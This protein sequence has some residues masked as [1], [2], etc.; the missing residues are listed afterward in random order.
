MENNFSL[1]KKAVPRHAQAI[2]REYGIKHVRGE[3]ELVKGSFKTGF[4]CPFCADKSGSASLTDELHF[5]CHQCSYK[6]DIFEWVGR[7]SGIS[8]WDACKAIAERVGVELKARS[9]KAV[10][11]RSMPS[12]MTEEI[13]EIAARDLWENERAQSERDMLKERGFTD[14][15]LLMKLG[16]GWIKGWVVFPS[17]DDQGNMLEKY[18]A[19][20]PN[21]PKVKWRWFGSGSGGPGI[22]PSLPAPEGAKILLC[23]GEGD[24]LTAMCRLRMHEQGWHVAT[25]TAGATSAPSPHHLPVSW[26]G[27]EV[28]VAYDNDVFQGPNYTKYVVLTKPGKN[29]DHARA[30]ARQRL[31][32]LLEGVCPALKSIDCKVIVRQCPV[33][34]AVN[35]GGDLRDWVNDGGNDFNDWK[36][37]PF[38]KLPDIDKVVVDVPFD[39]LWE[40]VGIN[41]RTMM[42]VEALGSDDVNVPETLRM[43][44]ELGQHTSCASCPGCREFPDGSIDMSEWPRELAVGL[45]S[46]N[47]HEYWAKNVVRRPKG[48]PRLELVTERGRKGS[49]WRGMRP[50][51]EEGSAQRSI[52]VV[53][54]DQPSL[55][56]DVEVVGIPHSTVKGNKLLIHAKEVRALDKGVDLEPHAFDFLHHCPHAATTVEEIDRYL[57][58]R[59]RDLSWNVTKVYGRQDVQIAWDLMMHSAIEISVAGSRERGWLDI[60]IIGDTR[61]GKSQTVT[62][63][64]DFTSMGKH[65]T[66]VSNISRAGVVMG[67]D[68]FGMLQPGAFP[69]ANGKALVL[70]ETHFL[71]EN[72]RRCKREHPLSWLQSARAEGFVSGIKNYG[73]R[74]LPARVRLCLIAN[75]MTGKRRNFQYRCQ[76][77]LELYGTPETLARTDFA[78][79]V[80][81]R[82]THST[83]TRTKQWWTPERTRALIQR[84]W[85][86]QPSQ[87]HI[88]E[89]SIARAKEVVREWAG[90]YDSER[91]PLFTVEEKEF[92]L[93]RSAVAIANLCF[94]HSK[95]DINS[96][97]VRPVHIE[98]VKQW[99]EHTWR[100]VQYEEWSERCARAKTVVNPLTAEKLLSFDIGLD[101]YMQVESVLSQMMGP[102]SV[103]QL[104]GM[105]GKNMGEINVWLRK[106][107]AHNVLENN[108][109]H[110]GYGTQYTPTEGGHKLMSQLIAL[111]Q[112]D[113]D[114]YQERQKF[115]Q[116]FMTSQ[117]GK[118]TFDDTLEPLGDEV[119]DDP[120]A[121]PDV[122]F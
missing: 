81:G 77:L 21:D 16:I 65:F 69:R 17:R 94:S 89:E 80:E 58:Q 51:N 35:Y 99:Y 8:Q 106:A 83:L 3:V 82:P 53:G 31:T 84:A 118:I 36:A 26:R 71:V 41:V 114:R 61:S 15:R 78:I 52:L 98:W 24:V 20:S 32:K 90:L 119:F 18:R 59:W 104:A 68:R 122:P 88:S 13:A 44:C 74:E 64:I 4:L 117:G 91:I 28:H 2:V 25:W 9:R 43:E 37:F 97:E 120:F 29:P 105:V 102:N 34:P 45:A 103:A 27:R 7:L 60:A 6:G 56:G 47:A 1:V 14:Q 96:V 5:K 111:A 116:R 57:E 63:M 40:S 121:E 23:E 38:E 75:W 107:L 67:A 93:L 48:C 87:V 79:A 22:W 73:A 42:Q 54:H 66:A 72:E 10:S 46:D 113:P 50:T 108:Q 85:A 86:Q 19:W 55:S 101:D 49:I 30:A 115:F 92:S 33:D 95:G 76:H 112:N 109:N 39:D 100:T 12:R 70:D 11:G 62:R 110:T